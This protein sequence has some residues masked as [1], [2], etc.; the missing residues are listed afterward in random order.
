MRVDPS[1][2]VV[3]GQWIGN[4]PTIGEFDYAIHDVSLISPELT[5]WGY[6]NFVSVLAE[7]FGAISVDVRCLDEECGGYEWE[8]HYKIPVTTGVRDFHFGPNLYALVAGALSGN[9][10]A[11]AAVNVAI[12]LGKIGYVSYILYDEYYAKAM[13]IQSLLLTYG[14]GAICNYGLPA[15]L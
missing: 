1:G 13:Y 2:L 3:R 8:E 9:A 14:P 10:K 4:S 11:S 5:V 6:V 7:G 12:I 15:T